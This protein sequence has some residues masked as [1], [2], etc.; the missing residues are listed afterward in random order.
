MAQKRSLHLIGIK[1]ADDL[2][3][4]DGGAL[5]VDLAQAVV[6]VGRL[7]IHLPL[8]P[9]PA[10][11]VDHLRR[12]PQA[13]LALLL[14]LSVVAQVHCAR[15]ARGQRRIHSRLHQAAV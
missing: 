1:D 6:Q 2:I 4:W 12:P 3:R 13:P 11:D 14:V 15:A 5:R 7:P 10:A 8:G 9:L